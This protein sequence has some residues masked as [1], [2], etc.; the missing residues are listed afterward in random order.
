VQSLVKGELK[1]DGKL[2]NEDPED[3]LGPRN[4]YKIYS[5]KMVAGRT[6]TIDLASGDFD[7]YLRLSD[8]QFKKLAE[9]DDSGGGTD[10]RIVFMAKS[11]GTHHIVA[12]SLDGQ[13]G[14]F[15][16]TVREEKQ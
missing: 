15:T 12:T 11:D 2:A 1:I 8:G 9:D 7:A 10:S 4:R 6:Y 14:S 3:M 16:L 13:V 5:V